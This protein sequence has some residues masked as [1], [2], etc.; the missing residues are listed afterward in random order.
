MTGGRAVDCAE[1]RFTALV[2]YRSVPGQRNDAAGSGSAFARIARAAAFDD[3]T[4]TDMAG[5]LSSVGMA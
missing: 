5:N 1:L 4:A 2:W 3:A